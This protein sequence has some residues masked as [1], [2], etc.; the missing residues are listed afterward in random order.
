MTQEGLDFQKSETQS[1]PQYFTVLWR[2]EHALFSPLSRDVTFD[3]A[4][5]FSPSLS[6]IF[7]SVT[8]P[9]R[10]LVKHSHELF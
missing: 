4:Q 5:H 7:V 3:T 1:P 10:R 2:S 8:A 6:G 9:K